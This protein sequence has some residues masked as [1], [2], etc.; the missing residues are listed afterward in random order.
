M[1]P[2]LDR[3]FSCSGR[4]ALITGSSSGIGLSMAEAIGRAGARVILVA[5]QA[6]LLAQNAERLRADGVQAGWIAADLSDRAQ[7]Q[8]VAEQAAAEHGDI[9]ILLH[10]AGLN[11]RPPLGELGVE[12]YDRMMAV[13]VHAAFLLGQAFGPAMAERGWGRIINIASQQA[14]RAFGNSGGY[15][16]T[17]AAVTGLTRSQAEAWSSRG[18]CC[19]AVGPGFVRTPLTAEAFAIP[20]RAEALAART[21]IG[22]NG[23]LDDYAGVAVWLASDASAYVTGQTIFVDGGFSVA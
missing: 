7:V 1:H 14:V 2:A 9:D 21:Q 20:G 22:R 15:G 18:V 13:N 8:R 17:K 3:L 4:T 5:R 19:N 10:S 11:L 16:V 12:D 23:E 6:E